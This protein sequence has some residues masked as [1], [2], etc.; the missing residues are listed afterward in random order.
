MRTYAEYL[1]TM[2][3]KTLNTIAKNMGLKG[4]S[5]LRKA[6]LIEFI[7]NN[8]KTDAFEAAE[9][10]RKRPTILDTEAPADHAAILAIMAEVLPVEFSA[11]PSESVA[12]ALESEAPTKTTPE[13]IAPSLEDLKAAYRNMRRTVNVMRC[14]TPEAHKRRARYVGTLRTY[15]AQLKAMGIKNPALL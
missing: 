11:A 15:S 2:T 3:V 14:P 6:E 5:K 9:I 12:E 7:D 4:Y 8:I 13:D 1:N 10:D